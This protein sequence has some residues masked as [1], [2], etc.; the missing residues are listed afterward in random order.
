MVQLFTEKTP[1]ITVHAWVVVRSPSYKN[2]CTRD[3]FIR[4]DYVSKP[5]FKVKKNVKDWYIYKK[6]EIK[7]AAEV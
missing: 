7:I 6:L 2:T 5:V 1:C 4:G 3:P